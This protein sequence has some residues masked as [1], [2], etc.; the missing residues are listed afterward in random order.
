MSGPGAPG[1]PPRLEA[2]GVAKRF[3][4]V[5]AL[6]D[7][8]FDVRASE[9]HALC[10]E[11]GAGKS[12]LIKVL[13]GIHP[14][15]SYSGTIRVDGREARFRGPRDAGRA[16]VAVIHQEPALVEGVSVAENLFLGAWPRRGILVDTMRVVREAAGLLARF[17]VDLDPETP[18]R[19][20][21][22]G[23]KQQ[24]EILKAVR[25]R[26]RVLIL[27]E[28][29]AALGEAE[30]GRLLDLVRQLA[31]EGVA[32][33]YI[34]HR[35]EEVRALADR[36]TVLR[37][38]RIVAA[39]PT[40]AVA[41]GELI[42]AMAG[43]PVSEAAPRRR[44]PG[45]G[46]GAAL[47]EVSRLDVAP[48]RGRPARLSG[49]SFEVR[50]GEVVGLAGLMGAGR[51]ELLLHCYGAWGVRLAGSV[52]LLGRR[53]DDATPRASMARGLA[54]VSEDRRRFGMIPDR[55]VEFNLTLSAL[56]RL[57]RR[58]LLDTAAE[59]QLYRA[60][61]EVLR[62]RAAGPEQPIRSLSGG[63]QQKVLLGRALLTDPR[64]ILLDEPTRGV[65]VA[66][67]FE[68]YDLINRLT[69]RGRAVLLVT[70]ELPELLGLSDRLLVLREG[71]IVAELPR[72]RFDQERVLAAALGHGDSSADS[73]RTR[74]VRK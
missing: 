8:E 15:G 49:L 11:N 44:P 46:A 71:R 45:G 72:E 3:G 64:V 43:R 58:G 47:L 32:C 57:T 33:V 13:A 25:R 1:D 61:A 63:N 28:P 59:A 37:D 65:D 20:L 67:K 21:G 54:L 38:G 41:A 27:D 6:E 14:F 16:G 7:V 55:S 68:I 30:A 69:D 4:G 40:G 34:T 26:S 51:S 48:G 31:R 17:G 23:R 29:T 42:R 53:H 74:E 62:V 9:V 18:A 56:G 24:V 73:Q 19:A 35:L 66:T 52:R 50:A 60:T 36:V 39:F 5:R 12:T 70:S 10:G 2:R 22:V